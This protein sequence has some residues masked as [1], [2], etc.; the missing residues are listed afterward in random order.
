M[1]FPGYDVP[2]GRHAGAYDPGKRRS[3]TVLI[4]LAVA[5]LLFAL[6]WPFV[7]PYLLETETVTLRAD[8]LPAGIGQLRVVYLTDVHKG[9]TFGADRVSALVSKVNTLNAD[10]VLLGG[11]YADDS[12]GAV[13]FFRTLPRI[14][15]R[16]GVYAVVGNHDRTLPES[17]LN[18]LRAAMQSAG[19]TPLVN[20][21]TSVRIG[22]ENIYIAGIDDVNNGHPDL[23]GV[24][25]QVRQRDYVIFLCHT[26][27]I[28]PQALAAEDMNRDLRWFDLGLFGHTH[29]GQLAFFGGLLR[30]DGVDD[31]YRSGWLRQNR[32]DLLI[33]RGVGTTVLPMRLFCRPQIHLI[34]INSTR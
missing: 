23:K 27:E 16:Y 10:I 33:S 28:I 1:L 3:R 22:T 13:E 9:G 31:Q 11:D 17:N 34:T 24:A 2:D 14:H 19:V 4:V 32:T 20:S 7:E 18:Q 6:A 12:S 29:G 25:A 26:P 5:A 30:D 15:S 8:D 21:V